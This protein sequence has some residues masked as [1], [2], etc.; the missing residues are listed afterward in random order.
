MTRAAASVTRT[1]ATARGEESRRRVLD[2]ALDVF[3]TKGYAAATVDDLCAAAG[4]TKGSFFHHF[5]SKETAALAAIEHWNR[6]TGELFARAPYWQI[7]DP[8][9]RL[10]G[11]LDFRAGLVRGERSFPPSKRRG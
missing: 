2:A 11:Y 7:D 8:R 9:D 3:R 5:D 6:T 10:H 4:V 1:A